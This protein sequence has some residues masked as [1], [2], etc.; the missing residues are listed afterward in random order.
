MARRVRRKLSILN[1]V[2][3][4]AVIVLLSIYLIGSFD[5]IKKLF[6]KRESP[7]ETY[8][9]NASELVNQSNDVSREF[10]KTREEIQSLDRV[11]M[12]NK[13]KK[14]ADN[15]REL[16][17]NCSELKVPEEMNRVHGILQFV[18]DMR[19][20][21]LDDHKP[22]LLNALEDI[23]VEIACIQLQ[24]ALEDLHLSDRAYEYFKKLSEL[25]LKEKK[26]DYVKIPESYFLQ[27][28]E[29]YTTDKVLE[30]IYSAKGTPE[31]QLI[32]GLAVLP[33]TVEFSPQK[34]GQEGEYIILLYSEEISVTI[35]I[36]NQGNQT[37]KE[38]PVKAI[39]KSEIEPEP[40]EVET[41]LP[42]IEPEEKLPVT[43]EG[44]KS[45]PG[46]KCLLKIIVG[47]VPFEKFLGNNEVEFKIIVER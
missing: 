9:K 11:D 12:I 6:G 42:E 25:V 40:V 2:I 1:I 19:A 45:Y 24:K 15:S 34:K 21:A 44:I 29:I 32:H 3:V 27:K 4:V 41:T 23:D 37:E 31:L 16:A 36:E 38:V 18:F 47:P 5:N 7:I 46:S 43:L 28:K 8:I 30:Y 22:A 33:D 26:L 39:L 14:Y 35:Y 17:N 10:M 13:L 20:A